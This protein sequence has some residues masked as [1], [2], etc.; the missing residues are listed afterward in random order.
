[1]NQ[2]APS[3]R[4]ELSDSLVGGIRQHGADAVG[5]V[6]MGLARLLVGAATLAVVLAGGAVAGYDIGA[7]EFAG[8]TGA[9]AFLNLLTSGRPRAEDNQRSRN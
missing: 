8:L 7:A 1:M 6:I 9:V 5:L 2:R 4:S 3:I